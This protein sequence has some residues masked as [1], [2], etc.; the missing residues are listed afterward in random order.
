MEVL[1]T[2]RAGFH[3]VGAIG[4][5]SSAL[6]NVGKGWVSFYDHGRMMGVGKAGYGLRWEKSDRKKAMGENRQDD[7]FVTGVGWRSQHPGLSVVLL[8]SCIGR[9]D[10]FYCSDRVP[11][12][13]FRRNRMTDSFVTCRGSRRVIRGASDRISVVRCLP[14][15]VRWRFV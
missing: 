4:G 9:I 11:D 2:M 13:W 14:G 6:R 5:W 12:S 1:V 15:Y 10:G 8:R 3:Q 7:L